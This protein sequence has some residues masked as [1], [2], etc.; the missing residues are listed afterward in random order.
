MIDIIYQQCILAINKVHDW[1]ACQFS[2]NAVFRSTWSLVFTSAQYPYWVCP[3]RR[4]L[5]AKLSTSGLCFHLWMH[6]K[7][8]EPGLICYKWPRGLVLIL[9]RLPCLHI[10]LINKD[11][12]GILALVHAA[13]VSCDLW[14]RGRWVWVM[15]TLTDMAENRIVG[16][17]F[18]SAD[19]VSGEEEERQ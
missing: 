17:S 14:W 18:F 2:F 4:C 7:N 13:A 1:C 10:V 3:N 8:P 11:T 19:K 9:D 15:A 12:G 6:I 16:Q 5:R